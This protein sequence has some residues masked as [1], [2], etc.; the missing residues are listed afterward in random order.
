[1]HGATIKRKVL[2]YL[3]TLAM[4]L[5][6]SGFFSGS[7]TSFRLTCEVTKDILSLC[8]PAGTSRKGEGTVYL[9]MAGLGFIRY[10]TGGSAVMLI[11]FYSINKA[12]RLAV[13]WCS[14][15]PY[16]SGRSISVVSPSKLGERVICVRDITGPDLSRNTICNDLDLCYL[17]FQASITIVP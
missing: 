3:C 7:L 12:T 16:L 14:I 1:M 15:T 2:W 5:Q 13:Q 8:G 11:D 6:P 17:F 9:F 10:S 4:A